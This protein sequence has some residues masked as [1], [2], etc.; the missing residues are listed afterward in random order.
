MGLDPRRILNA[1]W[2]S[3]VAMLVKSFSP[4]KRALMDPGL[5]KA[6]EPAP[7]SARRRS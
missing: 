4:E 1:H 7:I 6:A 3:N 2:Q 5:L